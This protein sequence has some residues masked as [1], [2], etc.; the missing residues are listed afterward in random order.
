MLIHAVDN[1]ANWSSGTVFQYITSLTQNAAVKPGTVFI[2]RPL[3]PSTEDTGKTAV[4]SNG[5]ALT[6]TTDL[7]PVEP[8]SEELFQVFI[9]RP[10]TGSSAVVEYC[11]IFHITLTY[12]FL[13][14]KFLKMLPRFCCYE[15]VPVLCF[16]D[17]LNVL[18]VSVLTLNNLQSKTVAFS[19]VLDLA[20]LAVTEVTL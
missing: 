16:Y 14:T 3:V 13:R 15:C 12:F 17:V 6:V 20:R 11:V 5:T 1:S 19:E 2:S 18:F 8:S 7:E 10:V 9:C 4:F